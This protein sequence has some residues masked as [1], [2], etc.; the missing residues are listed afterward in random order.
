L[1]FSS[2]IFFI[3]AESAE[4]A[5]KKFVTGQAV[6]LF[7]ELLWAEAIRIGI[8][9]NKVNVPFRINDADGGIEQ[10]KLQELINKTGQSLGPGKF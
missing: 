10:K 5:E 1:Q 3:T 8:G 7:G 6:N 2:K 9:I 4:I